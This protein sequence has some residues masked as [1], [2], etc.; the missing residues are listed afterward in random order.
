MK[1]ALWDLEWAWLQVW[2][3]IGQLT[4]A[5]FVIALGVALSAAVML[6]SSTLGHALE[7]SMSSLAG[8]AELQVSA[9]GGAEFD[10]AVLPI[11]QA[12]EGVA[13][14]A[15]LL[16]KKIFLEQNGL[17][18]RLAGVDMLDD[19]T[20]RV[21][22]SDAE[23][24]AGLEDPLL[25]LSQPDSVLFP[26]SFLKK[27]G[28]D[29]GDRV[30]IQAPSG[31]QV[32]TVRG[33]IEDEGIGSAFGGELGI[34]DIVSAQAAFVAERKISQIDVR[35]E[36]PA[37]LD[38]VA[39]RLRAA[40]PD[41][42]VVESFEAQKTRIRELISGFQLMMD[43]MSGL[44]LILAAVITGNRL[45]T[46]YQARMWEIGA[47]RALGASPRGLVHSFLAE[48]FVIVA[49]GCAVGLPMSILF[50]E[51]LLQPI[52]E[53]TTLNFKQLG[54]HL[55]QPSEVIVTPAPLLL[56][57][58]AGLVSALVAAWL[59][60]R[61]ATKVPV[62][63]ALSRG[64]SRRTVAESRYQRRARFV[65]PPLALGALALQAYG[66]AEAGALGIV[67]LPIAAALWITPGLRLFSK[68][69]GDRLGAAAGVGLE[70]QS[71]VPSRATGAAGVIVA[72]IGFV[73]F[74]AIAGAS[75]ERYVVGSLMQT[76]NGDLIVDSRFNEGATASGE[77]EPRL[78][79]SIVPLLEAIPGVRLAGAGTFAR[80]Y[81]PELGLIT[82][83]PIRFRNREFGDW[84]V[85][86]GALPNVLERAASGELVLIDETL[87][88]ARN[89]EPGDTLRINTPR[90]GLE[91]VVGGITRA[92]SFQSPNGDV[93]LSRALYREAWND[94]TV[95]RVLL[96][97]SE[98][99]AVDVVRERILDE[100]GERFELRVVMPSDLRQW[101]AQ[102]VRDGFASTT[103]VMWL[104]LIVAIVGTGDALSS[105]IVERTRELGAMR[106]LG[107]SPRQI[108]AMVVA[109]AAAIG[110]V[111]T[112][113]ASF[114]AL[115]L[116]SAFLD[117]ILP[118]AL[119]WEVGMHVPLASLLIP[120]ALG[121]A[122][123]VLGALLA[124]ARAASLPPIEALRFE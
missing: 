21:Y 28:L 25:F 43:F 69:V 38:Q 54:T 72:G 64:R 35:V 53:T 39:S 92:R 117:G 71:L 112:A 106:A 107:F 47:L 6:A 50:A 44:G 100:L 37:K 30:P 13:A 73:G 3:R 122:A 81:D 75:F 17:P 9:H 116:G 101:F 62:H 4:V 58:F 121:I 83:D 82:I 12:T 86:P 18:F 10:E 115:A 15:P 7:D 97:L 1:K 95:T 20:V 23:A 24:N 80:A 61:R 90:G 67:L 120:A 91:T 93:I 124:A 63:E 89:L 49:L 74:I 29:R 31:Q 32:L 55:T 96:L 52:T 48:A 57:A 76:R 56:A 26:R 11:V 8:R 36:N 103:W 87:A 105:T 65:L 14:A 111:G 113:L 104:A 88:S 2:P 42:L 98:A 102:T 119:G 41:H 109:Q 108:G 85:S 78:D 79:E 33:V 114:V 5:V 16:F 60:A 70:D 22:R 118:S 27:H 45:S 84:N 99:S 46:I 94:H 110:I 123:S 51:F 34:M 77:N 19:A 40:L 68:V 59:P 66:I